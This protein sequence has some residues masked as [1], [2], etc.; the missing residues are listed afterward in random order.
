[1]PA[2]PWPSGPAREV[3]REWGP[4]GRKARTHRGSWHLLALRP[5]S[6]GLSPLGLAVKGPLRRGTRT[7]WW[8]RCAGTGRPAAPLGLSPDCWVISLCCCESLCTRVHVSVRKSHPWEGLCT[9]TGPG[10]SGRRRKPRSDG[11]HGSPGPGPELLCWPPRPISSSGPEPGLEETEHC[12]RP[13]AWRGPCAAEGP[14][15]A[16]LLDLSLG[17]SCF[18]NSGHMGSEQRADLPPGVESH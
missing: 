6:S 11:A 1:M 3:A 12:R 4:L 14:R 5:R 10:P 17:T 7:L 15:R 18:P 16:R 2:L 8:W 9:F 13:A